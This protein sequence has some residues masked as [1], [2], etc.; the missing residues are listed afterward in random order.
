MFALGGRFY[1][2]AVHIDGRLLEE[3]LRL[4]RPDRQAGLINRPL[5]RADL[6]GGCKATA[7]ISRGCGIGDPCGAQRVEIRL[8]VAFE[9]DVFQAPA[10]GECVVSDIENV[11]RFVIG[12]VRLEHFDAA[13][14][15]GDQPGL[16][17]ERMDQSHAAITDSLRTLGNFVLNIC[18]PKHGPVDLFGFVFQPL[19]NA[20]LAFGEHLP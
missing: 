1:D 5:Q 8:V 13:I 2:V 4:P 15:G 16:R 3:L 20:T 19:L 12:E 18:S 11:I 10:V 7:E 9:F 17:G 14:N 6:L